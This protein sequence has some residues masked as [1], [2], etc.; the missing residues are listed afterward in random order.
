MR[1]G[2]HSKRS[3][4]G[5][6]LVLALVLVFGA[7]VG[8]TVAWLTDKTAEVKNTFTPSD[9]NIELDENTGPTYQMVPGKT[10]TKDPFVTVKADSEACWLFVEIIES[11]NYDNFLTY[12][13]AAGWTAVPDVD[14]VYYRNVTKSTADQE[15]KVLLNDTVTVNDT[16][17][18]AMMNALTEAT[19]PTL[20]FMAY[21]VQQEA[22]TDAA[23]AWTLRPTT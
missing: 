2:N 9:I 3:F 14:N 16:V 11:A 20:T 21:A 6:T 22:A 13:P 5:L 10:I 7:V 8:G 4:K 19:Y 17:T 12:A 15:F 1:K 23:T 18:K